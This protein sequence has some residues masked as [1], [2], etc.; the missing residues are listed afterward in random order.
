MDAPSV[1]QAPPT[2]FPAPLRATRRKGSGKKL[3]V[4]GATANNL[5]SVTTSVPL[6]TFTCITGVSGSGKS[7][8]VNEI[9]YKALANRLHRVRVT[10]GAGERALVVQLLERL[11]GEDL[12]FRG[13]LRLRLGGPRLKRIGLLN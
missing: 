1:V 2:I 10:P 8:L 3:T 11:L 12:V 5:R 6:G 9:V 7:T 4:K 13:G